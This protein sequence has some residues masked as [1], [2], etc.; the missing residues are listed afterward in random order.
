MVSRGRIVAA[1]IA[2]ACLAAY[3]E[4]AELARLAIGAVGLHI[5]YRCLKQRLGIRPRPSTRAGSRTMLEVA[6]AAVGG[7]ILSILVGRRAS[8]PTHPCAQCGGPIAAPSRR[9]YCEPSCAHYARLERAERE[10]KTAALEELGGVP[11]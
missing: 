9:V 6:A 3:L 1:A 5:C 11:Y 7:G 4:R 2:V 8:S 10:R